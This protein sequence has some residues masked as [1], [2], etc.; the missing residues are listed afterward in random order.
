MV[1]LLRA[2]IGH[3]LQ[4]SGEILAGELDIFLGEF[5]IFIQQLAKTQPDDL[6]HMGGYGEFYI[7]CNILPEVQYGLPG[8]RDDQRRLESLMLRHGN[9]IGCCRRDRMACAPGPAGK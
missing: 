1:F 2:C 8:G 5:A 4:W 6:A 7:A 3:L 9:V